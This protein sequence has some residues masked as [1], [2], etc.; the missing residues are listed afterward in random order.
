MKKPLQFLLVALITCTAYN[1]TNAQCT[2]SAQTLVE[3]LGKNIYSDEWKAL[4]A[5]CG[6]QKLNDT[7]YSTKAG[8]EIKLK[9]NVTNE[10]SLY[11]SSVVYNTYTGE[12]PR[13]LR[14]GMSTAEIKQLLGKPT[15]AYNTSG[16]CEYDMG[17]IILSCWLEN[18]Q[19]NQVVIAEKTE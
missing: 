9:G 17:Q 18:G 14:F 12:L 13:K 19:L 5:T 1:G 10:I 11:K 3:L 16:Y 6:F 8:I 2:P 15:V 7:H 4:A